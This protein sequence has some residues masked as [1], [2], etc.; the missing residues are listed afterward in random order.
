MK[1]AIIRIKSY[2]FLHLGKERWKR[3]IKK[4]WNYIPGS[5]LYGIIANCLIRL[6]CQ[7]G[8]ATT[9]NCNNCLDNGSI[10]CGYKLLLKQIKDHNIRFS[11]LIPSQVKVENAKDYCSI[12]NKIWI[13]MG[14][15]P[16]APIDREHFKI[17]RD[18]LFGV[19]THQPFQQYWGFIVLKENS[20][21]DYL[22]KPLRLLPL[23]PFGGRGKF[24]QIDANI[25]K[26]MDS[27]LFLEGLNELY[28][29]NIK[30]ITPAIINDSI[31]EFIKNAKCYDFDIK[32]YRFWRVGLYWEN[33]ALRTYEEKSNNQLRIK[34]GISEGAVIKLL[35]FDL[36]KLKNYFIRGIGD[37]DWANLGWGQIIF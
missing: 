27:E 25:I 1:I 4:T 21:K 31:L 9:E 10:E 5:T 26:I 29:G 23:T 35:D 34:R 8:V 37:P 19:L 20:F 13:K 24:S 14:L 28:R 22:K 30:L 18:Q 3:V 2:S 12:G 7:K 17:Y 36:K 33:G 11:P 32:W 16:H 6:E 15:T